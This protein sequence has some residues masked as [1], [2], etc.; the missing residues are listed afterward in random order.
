MVCTFYVWDKVL[1][2]E[3]LRRK[4]NTASSF[5]SRFAVTS[6]PGVAYIAGGEKMGNNYNGHN[7]CGPRKKKGFK[8]CKETKDV[9]FVLLVFGAVTLC[10]FFLPPKAWLVLLG[11]ILIICGIS[12]MGK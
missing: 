5:S 1:C 12:L 2:K 10:A 11:L 6:A 9:G 7:N 3:K 4:K 8:I